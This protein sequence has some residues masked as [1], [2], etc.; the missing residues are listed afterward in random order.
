MKITSTFLLALLLGALSAC[1]IGGALWFWPEWVKDSFSIG[2]FS[3]T[4]IVIICLLLMLAA[5]IIG[6]VLET[7]FTTNGEKQG[8]L[9]FGDSPL[10]YQF[11]VRLP[12]R[13]PSA[14]FDGA[15][16]AVWDARVWHH[17]VKRTAGTRR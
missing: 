6:W 3:T 16:E 5:L 13:E 11:D 15:V 17:T 7:V 8:T 9:T 4:G 1:L 10:H 14:L 12:Y 2:P